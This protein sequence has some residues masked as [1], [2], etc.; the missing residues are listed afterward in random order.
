MGR[1]L[2]PEE[3]HVFTRP[4]I[5]GGGPYTAYPRTAF[6]TAARRSGLNDGRVRHLF[7]Y[8][9]RHSFATIAAE[10]GIDRAFTK[11]MMRHS[12]AS[13]V[14]DEAYIRVSKSATARAFSGFGLK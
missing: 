12:R 3:G 8:I 10:S 6:Q 4:A 14:L 2:S 9:A 11:D 7:P 13:T 1:A 5:W